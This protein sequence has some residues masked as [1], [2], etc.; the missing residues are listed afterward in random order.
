MSARGV[1]IVSIVAILQMV[2]TLMTCYVTKRWCM[3]DGN[4]VCVW[5]GGVPCVAVHGEIHQ[6]G[7]GGFVCW[8]KGTASRVLLTVTQLWRCSVNFGACLVVGFQA[9]KIGGA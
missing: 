8:I 5:G 6:A 9:C 2:I 3:R 1:N 7:A 4:A